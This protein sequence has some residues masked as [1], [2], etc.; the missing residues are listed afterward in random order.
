VVDA[1][2]GDA[3][4]KLKGDP[5]RALAS[6]RL[7]LQTDP[8][9]ADVYAGL[10]SAMSL[11]GESAADRANAL[12]RYPSAD[13]PDSKMTADLVYELA[14]T[15]AEAMQ[16]EPALALFKNRFFP[17]E[18]GGITSGQVLFEIKLMQADAWAKAGN[19]KGAEEFLR[20]E[21]A[22]I[23]LNGNSARDAVK[24]GGIAQSCGEA[25]EAREMFEKA[26][27]DFEPSSLPW[28]IDAL[29]SLGTY[30]AKKAEQ[31]LE[32]SL[33]A[34][35]SHSDSSA[36]S[37]SWWYSVGLLQIA[38]QRNDAARESLRKALILPDTRMSHHLAREA[39][40]ELST[41]K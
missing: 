40:G 3:F 24:L 4:L 22:E 26:A 31:Q 29:K 5:Q 27:A 7:G 17:S 28:V 19:C 35:L 12:S 1:D 13:A 15:R 21:Q 23:K 11:T 10:D 6:Y 30:D 8:D 37:G 38:L 36:N 20:D 41:G 16:F 2:L 14:L 9:N 33:A 25:N 34:A 32:S 39:L 18:E